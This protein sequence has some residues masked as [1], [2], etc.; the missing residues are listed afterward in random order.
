MGT[1][2]DL[3]A[4]ERRV[5]AVADRE[6]VRLY[7]ALFQGVEYIPVTAS[8]AEKTWESA[9]RVIARLMELEAD[10]DVLLLAVGGGITTDLGGFVASVY[11][12]GVRAAYVPTTLLGMVDAAYGG[13]TGVNVGGYKN[14]AGTFAQPV[15]VWRDLSWLA[16]LPGRELYSGV[17]EMLKTFL[18]ADAPAY[19]R[20]VRLFEGHPGAADLLGWPEHRAE[21]ER[22]TDRAAALKLEIVSRDERESGLRRVLNF[23]HTFGHA[24]EHAALTLSVGAEVAVGT[25]GGGHPV[26]SGR[27]THGEA[28]AVGMAMAARLAV[29]KGLAEASLA[30]QVEEDLHR[31]GL[32][33]GPEECLAAEPGRIAEAVREALAQDKKRAGDRLHFVFPRAI[34][35]V[36]VRPVALAEL[37]AAADGLN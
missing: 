17:A 24:L 18:V 1:W 26:H 2:K 14:E 31:V 22:L 34:G 8:E 9:G 28:V 25:D 23:G 15:R 32:P 4:G 5:I 35:R 30:R 19:E 27:L 20:A 16:T 33:A 11:K 3:L 29:R 36:E 37:L 12:R 6:V 7:P 10:R 13:K 21:L